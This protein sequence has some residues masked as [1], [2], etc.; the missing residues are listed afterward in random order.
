MSDQNCPIWV[1]WEAILKNIATYEMSSLKFVKMQSLMPIY[2]HLKFRQNITHLDH[3][4]L[5]F[6]EEYCHV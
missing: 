6:E 2:K 5:N 3:F 4:R 1:F